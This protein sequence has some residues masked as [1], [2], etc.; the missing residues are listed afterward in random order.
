L[1]DDGVVE[2]AIEERGGASIASTAPISP[3]SMPRRVTSRIAS[4]RG[5][6]RPTKLVLTRSMTG[7]AHRTIPWAARR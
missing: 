4:A 6:F 5:I 3:R 7:G 1:N 2:Q